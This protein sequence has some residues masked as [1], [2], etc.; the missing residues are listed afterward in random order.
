MLTNSVFS[1]DL[2]DYAT[3]SGRYGYDS[4][5]LDRDMRHE[6]EQL[7][8]GSFV[9]LIVHKY[10]PFHGFTEWLRPDLH[11]QID[12]SDRAAYLEWAYELTKEEAAA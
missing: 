9:K 5:Q 7:P 6:M 3:G 12:Y 11:V 4:Y 8:A 10:M 1:I 2:A